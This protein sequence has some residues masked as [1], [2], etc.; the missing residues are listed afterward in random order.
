MAAGNP[1]TPED[2]TFRET[3]GS[4]HMEVDRSLP[5]ESQTPR[6]FIEIDPSRVAIRAK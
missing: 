1:K 4:W 5:R 3:E 6:F 2:E